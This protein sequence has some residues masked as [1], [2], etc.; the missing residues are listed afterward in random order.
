MG[1]E[2]FAQFLKEMGLKIFYDTQVGQFDALACERAKGL[3]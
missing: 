3:A 2:S 1:A